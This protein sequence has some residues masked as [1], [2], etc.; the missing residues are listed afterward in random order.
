MPPLP[1]GAARAWRGRSLTPRPRARSWAPAIT[2]RSGRLHTRRHDRLHHGRGHGDD[3]RRAGNANHQLVQSGKHRLRHGT[4]RHAVGCH[5]FLD[6]GRCKWERGGNVHLHPGHGHRPGR[7]QQPDALGRSSRPTTRPITR[8]PPRR[9]RSTS[10]AT[11]TISWS[12]PANILYG[13]ALSG[14]AVGC[15]LFLDS[16]WCKWGRGGRSLTPRPLARP[17]RGQ[18]SDALGR[19]SHPPTRPITR[20]HPQRRR[21]TSWVR[22]RRACTWPPPTPRRRGGHGGYLDRWQHALRRLRRFW[23]DPGRDRRRC[24][25][26][27]GGYRCGYLY[28]AAHDRR[29][30][31]PCR[32]GRVSTTI[33]APSGL[34]GDEIEIAGGAHGVRRVLSVT[35]A[36]HLDR[37][38]RQ[39]WQPLGQ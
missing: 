30:L 2:R 33:Q 25:R 37:H 13:T 12:N 29:E 14:S 1:D 34:S 11:P 19:F 24:R 15:H 17:R 5:L 38:R 10:Q 31:E 16:G 8:R 32:R 39:R 21:S 35:G 9:R 4:E 26:R 22:I 6:V 27:H 18:Q 7:R 28:R 36:Q 20:R 3:Q 23:N